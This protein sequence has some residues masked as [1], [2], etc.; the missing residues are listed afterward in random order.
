MSPW[1]GSDN[2]LDKSATSSRID[3]AETLEQQTTINGIGLINNVEAQMNVDFYLSWTGA[4]WPQGGL[5]GLSLGPCEQVRCGG[6]VRFRFH[7][8][9]HSL[10]IDLEAHHVAVD[11]QS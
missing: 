5:I 11:S 1:S 8:H 3:L 9:V 6:C 2:S 10:L 7:F 4:Q